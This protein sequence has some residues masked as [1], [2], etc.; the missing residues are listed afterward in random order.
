MIATLLC[1]S[2]TLIVILGLLFSTSSS[3]HFLYDCIE[4]RWV[5]QIEGANS[6]FT[7]IICSAS[8]DAKK[9]SITYVSN[10]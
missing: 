6:T 10:W 5:G 9:E 2:I 1:E 4:I 8:I 3:G 7:L